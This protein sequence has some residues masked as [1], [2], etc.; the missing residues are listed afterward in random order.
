VYGE[1]LGELSIDAH[2]DVDGLVVD[3]L[4]LGNDE[5]AMRMTGFLGWNGNLALALGA[6]RLPL[7]SLP[8]LASDPGLGVDGNVSLDLGIGG[9]LASPEVEGSVKLASL[10][11]GETIY[12]GG[13]LELTALPGGEVGFRGRI[14]QGKVQIDGRAQLHAPWFASLRVDFKRMEIAEFTSAA[15][16]VGA[17]GWVTGHVQVDVGA[18]MQYRVHLDEL[19]AE[20]A[21]ADERGRPTPVHVTA[22]GPIDVEY[23]GVTARLP[24]PVVLA[25]ADSEGEGRFT[26]EG[27]AGAQALAL[28]VHGNVNLQIV[29]VFARRYVDGVRGSAELDVTVA[30]TGEAPLLRGKLTFKDVKITPRGA[31][32]EILLPRG[33]LG[34][35]ND[36]ISVAQLTVVVDDEPLV[37]DGHVTLAQWKPQHVDAQLRGRFAA[38]LIEVAAAA[39]VSGTSGS[40]VID[41]HVFGAVGNPNLVGSLD[42]DS[43][44]AVAPRGLR[45]EVILESGHIGFS[46][47]RLSISGLRG[48]VD[49]GTIELKGWV[50]LQAW[51]LRQLDVETTMRNIEMRVPGVLELL[52]DT[53][54]RLHGGANQLY[55]SGKVDMVDGRYTQRLNYTKLLLVPERTAERATPFW[56]GIPLVEQM[57]LDLSITT[58]G[59]F[60]VRNN[61]V[62]EMTLS[63][64]VTLTGTPPDPRLSGRITIE[65]GRIK[66]PGIKPVFEVDNGNI[67]FSP[68]ERAA[69][70]TKVS[71]TTTAVHE[72][73]EERQHVV[74]MTVKGPLLELII[75]MFTNTGLNFPQTLVLLGLNRTIDDVREDAR[76]DSNSALPKQGAGGGSTTT[77]GADAGFAGEADRLL[78]DLAGDFLSVMVED[79]I[80]NRFPID[81]VHIEV[82]TQSGVVYLCK[83]ILRNLK[84]E[85]EYER[86]YQGYTRHRYG[87]NGRL[88]DD[89]S[90][91]FEVFDDTN[92]DETEQKDYSNVE[93]KFR[94]IIP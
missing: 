12:G 58:N 67:F 50:T 17:S 41:V 36:R 80:K 47:N 88:T 76:G 63:G 52:A 85:Y 46:N 20:I 6:E 57:K 27:S 77:A 19:S 8:F 22:E 54:L 14:F 10:A 4:M 23:D 44:F 9:N 62:P 42:F 69:E 83:K 37:L 34:F 64:K 56:N 87:V 32:A 66:L 68:Y 71:I 2:S 18:T 45:R 90:L 43:P 65:D 7:A 60:E 82:G 78:K 93:L 81:C 1:P 79:P 38:K 59:L 94:W 72:D 86:G 49:D 53:T 51:A 3:R 84:L 55:L 28:S 24:H 40:A 16:L 33:E 75:D 74:T 31:D 89:M 15:E 21:A 11:F 30:G 5:R 91:V 73:R 35:K 92:D 39:G 61:V 26:I 70:G 25:T 48:K 13:K 29:E